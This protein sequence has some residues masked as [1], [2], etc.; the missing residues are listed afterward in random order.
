VPELERLKR[1]LTFNLKKWWYG[2]R[3]EYVYSLPRTVREYPASVE[4]PTFR[5]VRRGGTDGSI[6]KKL[7]RKG[8]KGKEDGKGKNSIAKTLEG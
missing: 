7:W 4:S 5:I 1:H 3:T 6:C 2:G 8:K